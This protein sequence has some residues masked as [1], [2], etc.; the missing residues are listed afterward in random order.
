ML[1][2]ITSVINSN[3]VEDGTRRA[4]METVISARESLTQASNA[5]SETI[6]DLMRENDRVTRRQIK[7]VKPKD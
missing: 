5:L 7:H 2:F 4:A 3:K 6:N 1:H